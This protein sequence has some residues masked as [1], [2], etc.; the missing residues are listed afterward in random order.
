MLPI[1]II[2]CALYIIIVYCRSVLWCSYRY[3]SAEGEFG[4]QYLRASSSSSSSS[5]NPNKFA[6]QRL[7]CTTNTA[8]LYTVRHS[9]NTPSQPPHNPPPNRPSAARHRPQLI[10]KLD[11]EA[12]DLRVSDPKRARGAR[13]T[14]PFV[15]GKLV[16]GTYGFST[17]V[18]AA[19]AH[20]HV[21]T[22]GD[23]ESPERVKLSCACSCTFV[24]T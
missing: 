3:V 23:D 14:G 21:M 22:R 10:I 7:D 24:C 20:T 18:C 2:I 9:H 8:T 4:K 17:A 11:L 19:A 12:F 5:Y 15:H 1:Y 16:N 6:S 13:T